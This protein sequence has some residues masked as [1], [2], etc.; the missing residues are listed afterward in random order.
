[1]SELDPIQLGPDELLLSGRLQLDAA[2]SVL[3]ITGV[4]PDAEASLVHTRNAQDILSLLGEDDGVVVYYSGEP[5]V[6]MKADII[7][8]ALLAKDNQN[9]PIDVRAAAAG[10]LD[11]LGVIK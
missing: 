1:M 7:T 8:S 11:V 3:Q 2:I 5:T 4:N 6:A 10:L 9:L